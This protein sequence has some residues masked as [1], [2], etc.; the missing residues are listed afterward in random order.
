MEKAQDNSKNEAANPV[1][2]DPEDLLVF[3]VGDIRFAIPAILLDHVVRMVA[4]TPVPEAPS[5]IIGIINYHGDILPVFS[6]RIFFSLPLTS[7][8]LSDFLLITRNNR[9]LAIIAEQIEGIFQP[10]KEIISPD[11][12]ISGINGIAG[13]YRCSDGLLVLTNPEDLIDLKDEDEIKKMHE[14]LVAI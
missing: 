5:G 3:T 4:I 14:Y 9:H 11:S 13:I 8:N 2:H 6:L 1:Q 10:S 12:I 7:P